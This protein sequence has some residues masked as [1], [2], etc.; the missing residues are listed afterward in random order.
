MTLRGETFR[1][2]S[3]IGV[4][5]VEFDESRPQSAQVEAAHVQ[6]NSM[7]TDMIKKLEGKFEEEDDEDAPPA[8]DME[9]KDQSKPT[10]VKRSSADAAAAA[11]ASA[12][13]KAK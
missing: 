5:V 8:E 10:S 7:I 4:T 2:G 13:K 12:A 6:V 9:E 1:N 3:S 11:A